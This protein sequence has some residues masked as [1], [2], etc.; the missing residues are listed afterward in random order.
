MSSWHSYPKIYSVGHRAVRDL[1]NHKVAVQEK[2]DGSQFSFGVFETPEGPELLIR[3][4]GRVIP[5]GT[6]DGNFN[7]AIATVERLNEEG[8][9]C[10][11]FTYRGEVLSKPK[12]NALTYDRVPDGNIILFDVNRDEEAWEHPQD[13]QVFASNLGLECV[14][15]FHIGI[16]NLED[17]QGFMEKTSC[18]GG[19]KIE[20]VVLKPIDPLFGVD[21]KRLMAKHVS[22]AFKEVHRKDWKTSNPLKGEILLEIGQS[23]RTEARWRKA[24]QHLRDDG[25]LT[26][27][28]KDIGPLIKELSKDFIDEEEEYIKDKLFK[29]AI[30]NIKR[31]VV[32]GFPE[33]Y[34]E[35]LLESQFW[36]GVDAGS[37][38]GSDSGDLG[39]AGHAHSVGD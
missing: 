31:Q 17:I 25:L 20:G 21:G 12:H 19:Q 27:S 2:V 15:T 16:V 36:A 5:P 3:S 22:E 30:K 7:A 6:S 24:I 14:P 32:A 39:S 37:D 38:P 18:L 28:P 23:L 34:K 11:G 33:W 9:L 10:L 26:D 29:W 35:Q 4:K 1:T 13:V 8:K